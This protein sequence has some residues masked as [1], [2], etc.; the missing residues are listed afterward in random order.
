M[1]H[2]AACRAASKKLYL[3]HRQE[4]EAALARGKGG[5]S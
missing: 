3:R 1:A 4:I 2:T 5:A